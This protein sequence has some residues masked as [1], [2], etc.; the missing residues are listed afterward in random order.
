MSTTQVHP[1]GYE[2][3]VA[4]VSSGHYY[5]Y[6]DVHPPQG[7]KTIVTALVLHGFPDSA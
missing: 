5:R 4:K 1:L 2:S 6:V 7:V 3:K